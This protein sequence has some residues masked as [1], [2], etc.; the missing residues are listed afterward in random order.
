[1]RIHAH[2]MIYVFGLGMVMSGCQPSDSSQMQDA[3]SLAYNCRA[4]PACDAKA[5]DPG[6]F[7]PFQNRKPSGNAWHRGHDQYF[8]QGD[9]Q[10]IIGKFNYG[11]LLARKDLQGEEVDIYLLRGCGDTWEKLGTGVTTHGGGATIE[12]IP[13]DGGRVY[14]QIPVDKQLDVGRHRVHLV[15]AGD[16]TTT[17]MFIEVMPAGVPL[18]VSDVDGTLTT[19]E[20][21]ELG[22]TITGATPDAND[23]AA[24]ALKGLVSKG[25]RPVYLTAR[26]ELS[27]QRTRD[28]VEERA[29][30]DGRIETSLASLLGLTGSKAAAYKS[31]AL[32]RLVDK[33]FEIAYAFGNTD[34]DAQAY[35]N[36]GIPTESRYFFKYNDKK[37][38]GQRI[39]SYRELN[40]FASLDGVCE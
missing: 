22:S 12:G 11:N 6:A 40:N 32:N 24:E 14:F 35:E 34:T 39:E 28:F 4:I 38:G 23:G 27:V 17:E 19:S 36:A 10:W 15:V 26:P 37:F 20:L 16:H 18:F 2:S 29:F 30:P 5:P 9:D 3:S 7:R 1:M 31:D 8:K 13:D 25:Y 33:G 21:A